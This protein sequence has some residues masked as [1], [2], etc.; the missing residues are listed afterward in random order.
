M[1]DKNRVGRGSSDRH[2]QDRL[3]RE[4]P[5]M[6][7]Q[8]LFVLAAAALCVLVA[9]A[10]FAAPD[11][12]AIRVVFKL[13][14]PSF[15]DLGEEDL[16]LVAERATTTLSERANRRWGF[17]EWG[18]ESTT[19]Q[20]ADWIIVLEE[21]VLAVTDESGEVFED[22]VIR[23]VHS[24]V[25]DDTTFGFDQSEDRRTLYLWGQPKPVQSAGVLADDIEGR[26]DVQLGDLLESLEVEK[27]LEKVPLGSTLI[28]DSVQERIVVPLKIEDLR[29]ARDS[30]L[31][32]VFFELAEEQGHLE[33]EAAAAVTE[34]GADQGFVVGRIMDVVFVGITIPPRIWWHPQVAD[35]ITNASEVKVFMYEYSPSLAGTS[36]TESGV[37]LD[38]DS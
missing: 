5:A 38:P 11:R 1:D 6:K 23:L 14:A 36:A 3:S 17:L 10:A 30:V 4:V 22:S 8:D 20:V 33:L 16:A 37:I 28:A 29:A 31:G 15:S 26:L 24:G 32:V 27:F 18:V 13:D 9:G 2:H 7:Q 21:E 35:L 34:E 25:I 19:D 12:P